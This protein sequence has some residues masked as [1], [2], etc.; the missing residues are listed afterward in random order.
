MVCGALNFCDG[1]H[2]AHPSA[3][4]VRYVHAPVSELYR[5]R[6]NSAR[7]R[8]RY[9][10]DKIMSRVTLFMPC[11]RSVILRNIGVSSMG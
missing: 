8:S 2:Q 1:Q 5:E 11:K 7:L 3:H 10:K 4:E 6:A 9:D